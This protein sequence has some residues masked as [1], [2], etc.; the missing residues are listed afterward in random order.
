MKKVKNT[1]LAVACL[2]VPALSLHGATMQQVAA[3]LNAYIGTHDEGIQES[4]PNAFQG[5]QGYRVTGLNFHPPLPEGC[6]MISMWGNNVLPSVSSGGPQ[7]IIYVLVRYRGFRFSLGY[8][9][10]QDDGETHFSTIVMPLP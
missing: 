10:S 4:V 9:V 2:V 6:E 7:W 8:V 1:L 5:Q 3:E